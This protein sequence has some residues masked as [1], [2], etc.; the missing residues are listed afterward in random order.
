MSATRIAIDGASLALMG[1]TLPRL[2]RHIERASFLTGMGLAISTLL[3][4]L[5]I[6][7]LGLQMAPVR[8]DLAACALVIG[9]VAATGG[10]VEHLAFNESLVSPRGHDRHVAL[11]RNAAGFG[12]VLI[13]FL[14][15]LLVFGTMFD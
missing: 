15:E 3:I 1:Y 4:Y 11:R 13:Y 9:L 14:L 2:Y 12:A 6:L 10:R 7:G 8:I 5:A